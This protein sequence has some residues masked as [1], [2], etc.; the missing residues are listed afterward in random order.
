M[1]VEDYVLLL[2]LLI[3]SHIMYS[4]ESE[5]H[6][7]LINIDKNSFIVLIPH[8]FLGVLGMG[9]ATPEPT[10]REVNYCWGCY[11]TTGPGDWLVGSVYSSSVFVSQ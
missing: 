6:L 3:I 7:L 10:E 2:H 4:M 5:S 1:S 8:L 11:P 9:M